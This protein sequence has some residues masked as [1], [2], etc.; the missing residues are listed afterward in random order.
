MDQ[1]CEAY[2]EGKTTELGARW[3]SEFIKGIGKRDDRFIIIID[4]NQVFS[5]DD[6]VAVQ[7]KAE[8]STPEL[9]SNVAEPEAM[10]PVDE[11]TGPDPGAEAAMT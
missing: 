6:L 3:R 9:G 1:Y 4:I 8:L 11:T 7:G 5:T 10:P 2:I